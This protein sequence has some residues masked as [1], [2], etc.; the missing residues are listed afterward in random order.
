[1]SNR[2]WFKPKT[3]G[4]GVTPITW[5]GWAVVAV[6]VLAIFASTLLLA[7][8]ERSIWTWLA[9]FAVVGVV[10]AAMMAISLSKTDGT[11]QWRWGTRDIQGK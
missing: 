11:W 6:Y 1:M 5:E 8:P 2:F 7:N 3:Y 10:T 9:W 4:Y